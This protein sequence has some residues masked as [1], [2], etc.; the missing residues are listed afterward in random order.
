M[1]KNKKE[2]N[3][4]RS[5]LAISQIILL[6]T[7][8]IAITYALGGGIGIVSALDKCSDIKGA[9]CIDIN[10]EK[11]GGELETGLCPGPT[12]IQCCVPKEKTNEPPPPN[13]DKPVGDLDIINMLIGAGVTEITNELI[14][15]VREAIKG[16]KTLTDAVAEVVKGA[17]VA[18]IVVEEPRVLGKF[19][20]K[21]LGKSAEGAEGD[22]LN[23]AMFTAIIIVAY[24]F[25]SVGL[26]TG[27]WGRAVDVAFR[28]G[29][30]AGVGLG[31]YSGLVTLNVLGPAGWI[32][33]AFVML[34]TWASKFLKRAQDREITFT[35]KPWQPQ[36][37]GSDCTLCNNKDF[38]CTEYQCRSLG[39]G[40][41]LINKDT[42]NP[43]CIHKDSM[44][45]DPPTITPWDVLP[46]GY[47]YYPLP[48]GQYGVEIKF[49]NKECLPAFQPFSLGVE[50]DKEGYCRIEF[51]S[52]A[53]FDDM[54][55]DF[56]GENYFKTQHSHIIS[57][58]GVANIQDYLDKLEL[59]EKAVS[60]IRNDGEYEIYVRCM[61]AT[62]GKANRDEFLFKFCIEKGPDTTAPTIRG[63]NWKDGAPIAYFGEEESREVNIQVYTN[64]PAQCKWSREEKSYADME[65]PLVCSNSLVTFNAQMSYACSGKLT[66]LENGKENKFYFRCNDNF[67]NVNRQS[68]TLTLVGTQPLIIDSV[69]PDNIIIKGGTSPIKITLEA[70]TSAGYKDGEASCSYSETRESGTYVQ[71]TNTD[72]YIHST[73]RW[74]ESGNYSYFIQCIDWG[75]N[76]DTKNISFSVDVDTKEPVVVRAY[77][78]DNYLKII[79][80]EE[81]E[82]VYSTGNVGCDYDFDDGL[83]INS[84]EEGTEHFVD[85]DP[86]KT[87][88]IKCKDDYGNQPY[89]GCS[90]VVRAFEI[91]G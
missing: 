56:G 37:S 53:S 49:Q 43:K 50:L 5:L 42:D 39:T 65:N 23:A 7:G 40:C 18:D 62:N 29:I 20:R 64:E 83:S 61:A 87:F 11:C 51:E 78:E 27:D 88:Y 41:E 66:G 89:G 82:C 73:N 59:E 3:K 28:K 79:T 58:P 10:T 31:V 44:D 24:T 52:T 38:P 46:E 84:A 30:G 91:S 74:L 1:L 67:G 15:A 76:A 14:S 77:H 70:E 6:V 47:K 81:A 55:S 35:C 32:A 21:Y 8:I 2:L 72:S 90:I 63:F 26:K 45:V 69:S 12:N 80:N 13:T 57:F 4:E 85:W 17:G 16:G 75:G 25:I 33:S 68:K 19:L 36:S 60:E 86:D 54:E 71:F 9:K 48:K 22:A 34:G